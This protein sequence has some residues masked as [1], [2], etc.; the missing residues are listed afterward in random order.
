VGIGSGGVPNRWKVAGLFLMGQ[1]PFKIEQH[2]YNLRS[3]AFFVGR[4]WPVE[5]AVWDIIGKAT[6]QPVY[7]LLGG[8]SDKLRAYASTGEVRPAAERVEVS[9]QMVAEGFRAI[10]LR[11]HSPEWRDDVKTLEA[12][13]KAV[14][15]QST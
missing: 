6:G 12:V 14:G 4:P 10:K 7:R 9:K 13:R 8:G 3:M 5:I 2:V 1:D 11:F 15:D